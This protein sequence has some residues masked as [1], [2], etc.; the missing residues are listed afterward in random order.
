MA[1]CRVSSSSSSPADARRI[2]SSMHA[3]SSYGST[4]GALE[5]APTLAF[6]L[7]FA[8]ALELAPALALPTETLGVFRSALLLP[9]LASAFGKSSGATVAAFAA[10]RRSRFW[11]RSIRLRIIKSSICKTA[12]GVPKS[13]HIAPRYLKRLA[14]M[15]IQ[16]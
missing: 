3:L 14:A 6:E 10:S 8:F 12:T 5:S 4:D 15:K 1:F 9:T 7:A 11:S 2:T 16:R 13:W